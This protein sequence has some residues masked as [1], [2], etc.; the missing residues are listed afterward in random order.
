MSGPARGSARCLGTALGVLLVTG[1]LASGCA[2]PGRAAADGALPDSVYERALGGWEDQ[3]QARGKRL[4]EKFLDQPFERLNADPRA[5]YYDAQRV[6]LQIG[7]YL[8]EPDGRWA[9]YAERAGAAYLD[10][11]QPDYRMPGYERFPHGLFMA[12]Q[13]SGD[14]ALLD[15][16]VALRDRGPFADVTSNAWAD[17]WYQ[18]QYSREIAYMLQTHV[19]AERAGAQRRP[20]ALAGYV[21]RALEHVRIWTTGDYRSSEPR[22]QFCQAFMAGLTASALIEYYE[23]TRA[24]GAPD[25]RVP[26]RL[27]RLG[28]WLIEHMWVPGRRHGAFRYVRP[29]TPGVGGETP[30]P[31]LNMLIVPL[32]GWLYRETGVLR[33]RNVGDK[34]FAGGVS[35]AHLGPDKHFNQNYRSSFDYVQ[36]RARGTERWQH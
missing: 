24:S 23:L 11:V 17:G 20:A 3:M 32:Y 30:A 18:Q 31:D 13:R 15:A 10:Y 34:A 25:E 29:G 14:P 19:L 26:P 8:G 36:W 4:G 7:D 35:F 28:D 22:W 1:L 33:Y 16:L 6:F 21:D 27:R 2:T 12:Y 9:R 5:W